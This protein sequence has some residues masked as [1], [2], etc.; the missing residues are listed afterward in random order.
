MTLTP[1]QVAHY[2]ERLGITPDLLGNRLENTR[3][4]HGVR[5]TYGAGCRCF[6]CRAANRRETIG[7]RRTHGTVSTYI[8]GCRCGLCREAN[9]ATRANERAARRTA[10]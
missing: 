9:R 8:A 2:R 1:A 4:T 6:A 10:S 7:P 5:S 3:R